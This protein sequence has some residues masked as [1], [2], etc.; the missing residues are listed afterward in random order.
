MRNRPVLASI[1]ICEDRNCQTKMISKLKKGLK[2]LGP[3]KI[4]KT[5]C[6]AYKMFGPQEQFPNCFCSTKKN[7]QMNC[8]TKMSIKKY[9]NNISHFFVFFVWW[10]FPHPPRDSVSPICGIFIFS[11]SSLIFTWEPWPGH[12]LAFVDKNTD[13]LKLFLAF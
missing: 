5:S 8:K 6:G 1:R 7:C 4:C 2:K 3:K 12:F 13:F 10:Y 11:L 9:Q